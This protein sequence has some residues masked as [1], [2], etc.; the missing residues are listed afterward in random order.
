MISF[1]Q[2]REWVGFQR[3]LGREVLEY[4]E[5]K[6]LEAEPLS[7]EVQ[8]PVI[9]AK[10]IKHDWPFGKN[11]LYIPHGPE[12][13]FNQMTGGFKNPVANFVKWLRELGKTHK[14][15][16]VKV[17]PLV[18]SVAQALVEAGF[19]KSKKEIQP[20]KTVI[21]NLEQSE[22]D[23]L[24]RMH[25]KTRY[26]IGIA[27][28]HGVTVGETGS[29]GI[30]LKLLKKTAKRDKFSPHPADYYK[31]LFEFKGLQTKLYFAY[32]RGN[33]PTTFDSPKVVGGKPIAA[34][35]I[36]IY[37]DTGYYLHGASD[38]DARALMAP[39]ALHWHIIKQLKAQGL[40]RYDL[41]GID[42]RKW[43]GVTRFKLGWGGQ[44]IEYP[45]SFD[46]PISKFW[47]M[48]YKIMRKLIVRG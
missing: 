35:L 31:K 36:L 30:F 26:N 1:L 46:L 24:S 38:Y 25:H 40:K 41:W 22:D 6:H 14:A 9:T 48:A 32:A 43:P 23:L 34:A 19:R 33:P 18:D 37:G 16:F 2:S 15:I 12:M 39:Y 11:Y 10:I 27:D 45:G 29:V 3:S 21:I 17:E 47:Y 28:K 20:S 44:T 42:V 13:D 4:P 5:P 7:K 8:P